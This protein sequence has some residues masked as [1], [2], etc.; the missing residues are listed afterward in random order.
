M[1]QTQAV[2]ETKLVTVEAVARHFHVSPS[3]VHR[4]VRES[5]I[6]FVRASRRIV[7]FRIEDV[8]RALTHQA[9]PS[10]ATVK[11]QPQ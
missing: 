8:E 4:W 10:T 1:Q 5:S 7:R 3:A 9:N 2:H 6:P 11:A